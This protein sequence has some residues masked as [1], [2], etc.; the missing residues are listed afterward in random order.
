MAF[1]APACPPSEHS[2]L[3]RSSVHPQALVQVEEG[4]E[5][6]RSVAA[7]VQVDQGGRRPAAGAGARL[8]GL[9]IKV[10]TSTPCLSLTC[11]ARND[12][13]AIRCR[14]RPLSLPRS[15][16]LAPPNFS[17]RSQPCLCAYF[18]PYHSH[19]NDGL[20]ACL[21]AA[22]SRTRGEKARLNRSGSVRLASASSRPAFAVR[23]TDALFLQLCRRRALL[24]TRPRPGRKRELGEDDL[25]KSPRE[26]RRTAQTLQPRGPSGDS[27]VR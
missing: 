17:I 18:A 11:T 2:P 5:D 12:D 16:S 21:C 1:R 19:C 7:A 9:R 26:P 10:K 23:E 25:P 15:V 22:A 4:Q 3:T 13:C 24:R 6:D 20:F 27:G 14:L 8:S